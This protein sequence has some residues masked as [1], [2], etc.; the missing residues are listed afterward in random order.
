MFDV[1]NLS[2][3]FLTLIHKIGGEFSSQW[4]YYQ[5]GIILIL[6]LVSHQIGALLAARM[7]IG[8]RTMGWPKAKLERIGVRLAISLLESVP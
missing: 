3:L 7:H 1:S 8:E 4:F 5:A 6:G 2:Q